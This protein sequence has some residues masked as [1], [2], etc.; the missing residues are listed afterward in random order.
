[1]HDAAQNSCL[2]GATYSAARENQAGSEIFR[3]HPGILP[4]CWAQGKLPRQSGV[5]PKY[6][7]AWAHCEVIG[8]GKHTCAAKTTCCLRR[9]ERV[10]LPWYGKTS[11]LRI[12][13]PA[14]RRRRILTFGCR[15]RWFAGPPS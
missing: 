10:T 4:P 2:V 12:Q 5:Y 6:A 11:L 1:L 15:L 8:S 3:R 14:R 9:D 7:L 13:R